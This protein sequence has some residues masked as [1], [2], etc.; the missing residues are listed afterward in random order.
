MALQN[1]EPSVPL[2]APGTGAK[3]YPRGA[4]ARDKHLKYWRGVVVELI[5]AR[6]AKKEGTA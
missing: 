1:I 3:D 5:K 4:K 2:A 6:D